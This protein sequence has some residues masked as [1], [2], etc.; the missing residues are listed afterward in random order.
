MAL[1]DENERWINEQL[2]RVETKLL[3]A[4]DQWSSPAGVRLRA[5]SAAIRALDVEQEALRDRVDKIDGDARPP[6]G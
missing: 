6:L 1:S 3:T 2:E 4:F 5:H